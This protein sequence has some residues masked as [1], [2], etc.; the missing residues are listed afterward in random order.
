MSRLMFYSFV[1]LIQFA[2]FSVRAAVNENPL[3]A[4]IS[5]RPDRVDAGANL[6][7]LIQLQLAPLHHA[8]LEQFRLQLAPGQKGKL[9]QFNVTPVIQFLDPISKKEKQG[10]EN[11]AE[12]NA[13]Y[14]VPEEFSYGAQNLKLELTYQ[15]C[16][17]EY[18]LFPKTIPLNVSYM[19]KETPAE[20]LTLQSRLQKSFEGSVKNNL[21]LALVLVFLAGV[22]TSLTPCIFPLIPITLAVLSGGKHKHHKKRE[23]FLRALCY[24]LGIAVTYSALGVLAASSGLL[25]GSF[26]GHPAVAAGLATLF[27]LMA[28]SLWGYF[29]VQLPPK[30]ATHFSKHKSKGGWVGCFVAGLLAGVIASPCVGPV[31]VSILAVVAQSG[32][33]F[34]GFILL[35]VFALGMGQ[36]FLWI[37]TFH[38]LAKKLPRSG[39]WMEGVKW[40]FGLLI[41]TLGF[42]YL[43]PVLSGKQ[44]WMV[45]LSVFVIYSILVFFRPPHGTLQ[46]HISARLALIALTA[47]T[48]FTFAKIMKPVNVASD[49][50]AEYATLPWQTYSDELL[51]EARKSGKAILIDFYA[52]WCVACKEL[53]IYTFSQPEVQNLQDQF[54]FLKFDATQNSPEFEKLRTQYEILGLPHLVFYDLTGMYRKDVTA[55]GFEPAKPFAERMKRA[56]Q[57]MK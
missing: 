41:M 40:V 7:V 15:A 35:F 36:L 13:V 22:L 9:T 39:S 56:L 54:V 52:D 24:V 10:I 12:M 25:F 32:R 50:Q 48:I 5:I 49:S 4:H 43:N 51:N 31:L 16:T 23:G 57:P 33:I 1:L 11:T 30:L 46:T 20:K 27:F 17:K 3:S 34:L 37:G 45:S 55:T 29:E 26:L 38:G 44:F 2:T 18:C 42:Y 28:L 47:L 6:D 21:L 14:E 53:E 8:Y 19:V